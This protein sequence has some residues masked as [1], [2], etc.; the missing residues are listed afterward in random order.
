MKKTI[1]ATILMVLTA[2]LAFGA[3][4]PFRD[5][6][7]DG[8]FSSPSMAG[9]KDLSTPFGF[10]ISASSDISL[11]S[12]L[13]SPTRVLDG[14]AESAVGELE[15]KDIEWWKENSSVLS[16]FSSFD[17]AFP[18]PTFQEGSEELELWRL[19]SYLGDTFLSSSY[20]SERRAYVVSALSEN[21]EI[22]PEGGGMGGEGD[23]LLSF[24]GSSFSP[25]FIWGWN[26]NI[27]LDSRSRILGGGKGVFGVD[28]RLPFLYS[29]SPMEDVTLGISCIPLVRMETYILP[30]SFINARLQNDVVS[31]F[32]DDFR[33]GFGLGVDLGASY[34]VNE[35][36]VFSLD[37]RNIPSM[38]SYWKLSLAQMASFDFA[39]EKVKDTWMEVPDVAFGAHWRRGGHSVDVEMSDVV[40][41]ILWERNNSG[42]IFDFL[43]CPK[44]A[45][46]YSFSDDTVFSVSLEGGRVA[47]GLEYSGFV[48]SLQYNGER[49]NVGVTVGYSV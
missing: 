49:N 36:L 23:L 21:N 17:S 6:R 48:F 43:L 40:S 44:V 27:G 11:I 19:R 12:F 47:L 42:Y 31:L 22:F 30:P 4:I 29:F 2:S 3:F 25:S 45:Y 13:S 32:S 28:V 41:Q 38:R 26:V 46:A 33:F 8:V 1:A 34:R 16:V 37:G 10:E 24:F 20:S 5:N 9:E 18:Y 14:A 15:A 7:D 39:M 35:E